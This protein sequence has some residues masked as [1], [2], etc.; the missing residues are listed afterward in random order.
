MPKI[1]NWD[2]LGVVNGEGL[3]KLTFYARLKELELQPRRIKQ[4]S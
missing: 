3:S 4:K 1:F 2:F